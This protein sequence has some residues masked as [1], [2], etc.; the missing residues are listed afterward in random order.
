MT[1]RLL[2]TASLVTFKA[3]LTVALVGQPMVVAPVQ[4]GPPSGGSR[5]GQHGPPTPAME[6]QRIVRSMAQAS[7]PLS[8]VQKSTILGVLEDRE[9]AMKALRESGATGE[10]ARS[11]RDKL[12]AT[13]RASIRAALTEAQAKVFDA[14]SAGPPNGGMAPSGP[15]P[16]SGGGSSAG[17]DSLIDA[18]TGGD[19]LSFR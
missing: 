10:E 15:P 14:M 8:D 3:V 5:G 16:S 13:S 1:S 4:D 11:Q 18:N 6:L 7:V 12:M 9:T 19:P 2:R 17:T